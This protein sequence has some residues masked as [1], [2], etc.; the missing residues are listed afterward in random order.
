MNNSQAHSENDF[1][2]SGLI[3]PV[4]GQ[5]RFISVAAG[6]QPSWTVL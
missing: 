4:S 2:F 1:T 5:R 6:G 3:E